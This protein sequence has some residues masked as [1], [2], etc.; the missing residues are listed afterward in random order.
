MASNKQ[1]EVEL[2]SAYV[3]DIF[4][5]AT[6]KRVI[7][8]QF[9]RQSLPSVFD[10]FAKITIIPNSHREQK[11]LFKVTLMGIRMKIFT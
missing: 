3:Y 5:R 7:F 1:Y 10:T 8:L 4:L 6:W 9:M 11:E 2:A